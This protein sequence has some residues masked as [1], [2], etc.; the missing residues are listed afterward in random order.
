MSIT[1]DKHDPDG[2]V[3]WYWYDNVAEYKKQSTQRTHRTAIRRY[4][5]WLASSGDYSHG[6]HWTDIDL[7]C[8]AREEM[9]DPATIDQEDAED[10]LKD[11]TDAL[12]ADT[13]NNTVNTLTTAYSWL[14]SKT[15]GVDADPFTYV[16]DVEG[17]DILDTSQGRDAYMIPIEEAR[18]YI[19]DWE[20]PRYSCINQIAAKYTRRVGGISNL[21]IEDINI[22]HPACQWTVHPD[23][24]HR[25][26]HI[27]FRQEKAESDLGRN[28]GNKTST[29]AKY[30]LDQELK[31]SL[32]WYLA[33]RPDPEDPT[34]PLFLST[35]YE[36]ESAE[37]ISHRFIE[38]SKEITQRDD[39]PKCWY[40]PND[41]DNLNIHYW[42]HWATTWY[43]DQTG[44][45]ALV[46]YLRGDTGSGSSANYDQYS[47]VKRQ[48][49]LDAMPT[50]FE[51]FI[52]D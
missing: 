38:K 44:D 49:I 48:K 32:L 20:R 37:S 33:T 31:Q 50:F 16:L 3:L 2:I 27:L 13:Q 35:R 22:D 52:D 18:Y 6:C 9:A 45:Q 7:D 43:Q 39:G 21:D 40:E 8:V 46:D 47:D 23:I 29:T 42:R 11:L 1:E 28:S 30:P 24:R 10:F 51:R 5:R 17:K 4:E 14:A 26:D 15:E 19:R 25:D 41:D 12:S 34:E 36:R